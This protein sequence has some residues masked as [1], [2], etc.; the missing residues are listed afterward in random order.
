MSGAE[1]VS[2]STRLVAADWKAT[3]R[4]S[5]LIAGRVPGRSAWTAGPGRFRPSFSSNENGVGPRLTRVVVPS[6]RSRTKTSVWWFVSAGTRL[7]AS[8]LKATKRP[9]PET[10]GASLF[11]LPW[12][13]VW[14]TLTRS[15]VLPWRS[16]RKTSWA[17][18]LS[19]GATPD[20]SLEKVTKRPS[21]ETDAEEA[22]PSAA[23]TWLTRVTVLALRSRTNTFWPSL[24]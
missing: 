14:P 3:K 4:P 11:P 2:F 18:L 21:A 23:A 6:R 9:S 20:A 15:V 5:A 7:V 10:D 24:A 1:L 19:P 16:D 8:E 12:S 13:P 22:D 17:V